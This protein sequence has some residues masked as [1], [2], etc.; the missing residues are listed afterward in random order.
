MAAGAATGRLLTEATSF[1]PFTSAGLFAW[2]VL[3]TVFQGD[4]GGKPVTRFPKAN[5]PNEP[6][7]V[8]E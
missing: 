6:W 2:M 1:E 3:G 8:C 7:I 4:N 5:D